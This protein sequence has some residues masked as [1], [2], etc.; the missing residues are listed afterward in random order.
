MAKWLPFDTAS[1]PLIQIRDNV[2]LMYVVTSAVY[3]QADVSANMLISANVSAGEFILVSAVDGPQLA[4]EPQNG[5]IA[6][7]NGISTHIV[8]SNGSAILYL[9]DCSSRPFITGDI[10]NLGSWTITVPQSASTC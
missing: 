10:V 7:A 6:E 4:I 8:L 5:L 2:S 9:T 1:L 3:L